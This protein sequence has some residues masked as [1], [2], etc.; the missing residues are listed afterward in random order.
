MNIT[1]V[2]GHF[3][4]A[5]GYIEVHLARAFAEM[6]HRVT[7]VTSDAVPP[8]VS[9]LHQE[10]GQPPKGVEV[11]RLKS[12]FSL[13][14]IV[15][16]RG[17]KKAVVNSHPD[18]IIV[19]GLG[20][21]FPKPALGLGVHTTVLFGDNAASYGDSPS[22]KTRLLFELFKRATYQKAAAKADRL[23]AYTPESFE[24][25]G[26]MLGGKWQKKLDEQEDFISLGFHPDEFFFD[27]NLRTNK[28]AELGFSESD[29]VVVTATRFRPEKNLEWAIPAFQKASPNTKWLLLGSAE[30]DYAKQLEEHLKRDL[31]QDRFI[32]LPHQRRVDLNA[33]YNAADVA[34]FTTPAISIIESMGIGLPVFLP[35]TKSLSHLIR[36]S[37]QGQIVKD[38]DS[39]EF[40][41]LL[42]E[43]RGD[44]AAKN[45]DLFSWKR[46]AEL[47]LSVNRG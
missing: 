32:L 37:D 13:G 15:I 6:G 25:A 22:A 14:Q 35:E 19:I 31:G 24:A 28:R 41:D 34:L 29:R 33:F 17:V 23:V 27:E 10:F 4:P 11:I 40:G 16:S 36:E 21:R 12:I 44:L 47:L 39:M 26:R 9:H 3:L 7:V 20:K 18:M 46:Q 8:Y 38:F 2:C 5:M 43:N 1:I 45:E 30:D 42:V